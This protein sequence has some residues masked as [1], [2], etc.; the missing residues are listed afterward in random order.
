MGGGSQKSSE[1]SQYEQLLEV[2]NDGGLKSMS[3]TT[4][5][6]HMFWIKVKAE[7]PE[8]DTNALK[9]LLPF[10]TSYL[11]KAA[12]SVTATKTR[13]WNRPNISNILLVS[14]P[15]IIPKWDHLVAVTQAQSSH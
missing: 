1:T 3:E 7:Y 12:F 9:S 10:P 5:N 14:L 11:S 4:S 15:S 2:P 8:V 6:F 13:L